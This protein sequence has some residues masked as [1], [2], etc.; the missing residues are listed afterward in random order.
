MMVTCIKQPKQHLKL[1]K[2]K[3]LSNTLGELK[4]ALLIKKRVVLNN[5]FSYL[6]PF[7]HVSIFIAMYVS[8]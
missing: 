5:R 4:K 8:L 1:M 6:R 3:K 7:N 2:K